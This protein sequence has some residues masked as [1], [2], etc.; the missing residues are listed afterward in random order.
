MLHLYTWAHVVKRQ[1]HCLALIPILK[2]THTHTQKVLTSVRSLRMDELKW[3]NHSPLTLYGIS[4][5][6]CQSEH[7]TLINNLKIGPAQWWVLSPLHNTEHVMTQKLSAR[8]KQGDLAKKS[9]WESFKRSK[10]HSSFLRSKLFMYI[11]MWLHF[12]FSN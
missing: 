9:L 1:F 4:Y 8:W 11:L 5:W 6:V 3:S 10:T 2:R 12:F 7:V